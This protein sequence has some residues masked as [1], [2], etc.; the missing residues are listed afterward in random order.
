LSDIPTEGMSEMDA[1]DMNGDAPQRIGHLHSFR[2]AD[3]THPVA[4]H[5]HLTPSAHKKAKAN[6]RRAMRGKP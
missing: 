1:E 6:K 4:H 3:G 2:P 5:P